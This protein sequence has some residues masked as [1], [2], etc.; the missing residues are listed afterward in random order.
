MCGIAG[1]FNPREKDSRGTIRSMTARLTHRGPDD[2]GFFEEGSV[3]LG[4]RRLSIIDL[5]GGH[6]PLYNEDQN[7]V[8]VFN[9]EIFNY[10]ELRSSL[11]GAGHRFSSASDA[12]VILHLFE[13]KGLDALKE[14]NGMYAFCLWDRKKKE[15]LLVRDRLG[16]KP[17]YYA[18]SSGGELSFASEIKS[19]LADRRISQALDFDALLLALGCL[20][21]P[22]PKTPFQAVRK[23]PPGHL[24]RF[25]GDHSFSPE[26]YWKIPD[27]DPWD[28]DP[29]RFRREFLDLARGAIEF[30][31]RSD[32]PVGVFLS[33][34][35]DS[36]L[37]TRLFVE[38]SSA[39]VHSFSVSYAGSSADE[40][41][42]AA[43]MAKHLGCHHHTV[44]VSWPDVVRL[45]PKLIYHMDEPL[46]DSALVAG[47]KVSELAAKEVKVILN[48]TG[49]D[50]LLGG[51]ARYQEN[52]W[53]LRAWHSVGPS[54]QNA[55][56]R[57]A[58]GWSSQE[59]IEKAK[60]N[61]TPDD[62]YLWRLMPLKPFHLRG[63][64][65]GEAAFSDVRGALGNIWPLS[66]VAAP[67]RWMRVDLG[68]YLVDDLLLL[69]DKM[70]M[71]AS[72]E[73]RVPLLDHR[74]VEWAARVPAD[75][76]IRGGKTKFGMRSWMKGL[77]PDDVLQRPKRGFG[78]PV[79]SWMSVGLWMSTQRLISER[80]SSRGNF[81]W[82]LSGSNLTDRLGK[83]NSQ[84]VFALLVLEIWARLFV[85][86]ESPE[87]ISG[88]L[89][90]A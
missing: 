61:R 71:A 27:Q 64:F 68:S 63:F 82:G 56:L 18:S 15:G 73:G 25:G 46:A 6:Q 67:E 47:F 2:Q 69:L 34:G 58:H 37:I 8:L 7:L 74:L 48:G 33:G 45:L 60:N 57:L 22:W 5:V 89:R 32:V 42:E 36:S 80:P 31:S 81:F 88:R 70:T 23:L 84:Q 72:I 79:A 86:G 16:I 66:P 9:G 19:L 49:G 3:S 51:Y 4:M 39:P 12:E 35:L 50:E 10:R 14:I 75:W 29:N 59:F 87:E 38:R 28:D 1:L 77:L 62:T 24:L 85:E 21:T 30:Q 52:P 54:F 11:M 43:A 65:A 20:F 55:A 76:K 78:A 41:A 17:L 90:T 26:R 44:D 53:P 83:L 40:G 13:D